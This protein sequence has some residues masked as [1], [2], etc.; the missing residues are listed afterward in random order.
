M[1]PDGGVEKGDASVGLSILLLPA[2]ICCHGSGLALCSRSWLTQ[3]Q[4]LLLPLFQRLGANEAGSTMVLAT[5]DET[6]NGNFIVRTHWK[7]EKE[8]RKEEG[9]KIAI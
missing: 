9:L 5:G 3:N 6:S 8:V 4:Y 7:Q 1:A 2:G